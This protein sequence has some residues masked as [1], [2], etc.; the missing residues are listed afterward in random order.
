M[1]KLTNA[2]KKKVLM[3][4]VEF[5]KEHPGEMVHNCR[6]KHYGV[7]Y[8]AE[9]IAD[10]VIKIYRH[11][12]YSI[13]DDEICIYDAYKKDWVYTAYDNYNAE[14]EEMLK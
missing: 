10:S 8:R 2:F 13:Y 9:E 12:P 7:Y 6:F 14:L 4:L 1:K 3:A 5:Q 11:N